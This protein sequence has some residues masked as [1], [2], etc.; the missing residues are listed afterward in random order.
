MPLAPCSTQDR[1]V[2]PNHGLG[3]DPYEQLGFVDLAG[4]QPAVRHRAELP[5][6]CQ[7]DYLLPI[8][9]IFLGTAV[10]LAL[11]APRR[12]VHIRTALLMFGLALVLMFF[13][14][15][16]AARR[17]VIGRGGA[18]CRRAL[19]GWLWRVKLG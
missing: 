1:N 5:A 6:Y 18:S 12:R 17:V 2:K 10:V 4:N 16:P 14:A 11:L 8:I 19:I 3:I 13:S 15:V 7:Q 9:I